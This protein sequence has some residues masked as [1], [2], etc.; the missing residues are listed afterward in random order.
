MIS[1][2]SHQWR[3][4]NTPWNFGNAFSVSNTASEFM[5]EKG[6]PARSFLVGILLTR[7]SLR[8]SEAE[9]SVSPALESMA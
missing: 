1:N 6:L 3:S 2:R 9:N 5:N 4:V 8:F 7:V